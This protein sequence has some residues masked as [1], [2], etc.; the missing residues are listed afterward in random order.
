KN[1]DARSD[2]FSSGCVLYEMLTGRRTF[3][4]EEVSDILASVLAREPDW[5]ALPVNLN[6]AITGLLRRCLEKSP[7]RRWHAAGDL[8]IEIESVIADP[9]GVIVEPSQTA[10]SAPFWKRAVPLLVTA[11][12]TAAILGGGMLYLKPQASPLAVTR[13]QL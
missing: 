2:V 1:A 4:G 8:R 5:S 3:D 7:K 10:A 13:F 6:P 9:Q 12:L 11:S